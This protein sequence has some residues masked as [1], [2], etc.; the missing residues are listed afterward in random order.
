ME[1]EDVIAH[2]VYDPVGRHLRYLKSRQ[3]KGRQ[4]G[5][6]INAVP[7]IGL[8]SRVI[9]ANRPMSGKH[10]PTHATTAAVQAASNARQIAEIRGRLSSLKAHLAELLA[11]QKQAAT[12]AKKSSSSN[13]S[14]TSSTKP[15]T[16]A[17][18]AAA[19]KPKTAK[20][21]AAAKQALKKAQAT[22]AQNQKNAPNKPTG[23]AS[24]SL[25]EQITK[26]RAVITDV[27]TKLRAAIDRARTQTAS[28]GR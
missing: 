6:N 11:K 3:L 10:V 27:E 25:S 4:P 20:Q 24:L 26:T 23:E 8:G 12:K 15:Q 16:A 21:K 13:S 7:K 1:V 5:R 28:N 18:K 2:A 14:K 9:D 17:Q 22:R 19:N